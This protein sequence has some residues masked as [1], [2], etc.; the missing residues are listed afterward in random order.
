MRRTTASLNYRRTKNLRVVQRLLG[1]SKIEN[2]V[3]CLGIE[4]DDA[5]EIAEQTQVQLATSPAVAPRGCWLRSGVTGQQRTYRDG[6]REASC[7][8]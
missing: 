6:S 3:R 1:H 2:T 4:V 7:D 5:L 8:A